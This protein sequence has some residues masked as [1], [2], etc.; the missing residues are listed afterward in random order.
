MIDRVAHALKDSMPGLQSPEAWPWRTMAIAAIEAMR[1]PTEAMV[2]A[3]R[4]SAPYD[5]DSAETWPIMIDE[6]LKP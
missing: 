4:A 2:Q 1:T 3:V 6:A 5:R